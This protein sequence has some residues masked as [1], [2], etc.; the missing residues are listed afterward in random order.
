VTRDEYHALDAIGS[1]DLR[2]LARSPAHFR[3]GREADRKVTPAMAFG[4]DVHTLVLEPSVAEAWVIES[5]DRRTKAGKARADEAAAAGVRIVD[6]EDYDVMR[7]MRDSIQAHPAARRLLDGAI[8][9]TPVTW[10]C[11]TT[12]IRC[13]AL[14]DARKGRICVDLKTTED[15]SPAGFPRA[16]ASYSLHMQAAHYLDAPIGFEAFVFVAV[17]K[18]APYAVGVYVLDAIS[19]ENAKHRRLALLDLYAECLRSGR[20]PA[21][22]DT[23]ETISLPAWAA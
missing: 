16:V 12:G 13:K 10:E 11:E 15:A 20:W 6:P 18:A 23:I 2:H 3:A 14:P 9:E 19:I 8:V 17:E 4:T 22:A 21:Y 7:R 5:I 1:A